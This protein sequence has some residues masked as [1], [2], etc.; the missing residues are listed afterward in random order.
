M[1]LLLFFVP[2]FNF[3]VCFLSLLFSLFAFFL[4]AFSFARF[5]FIGKASLEPADYPRVFLYKKSPAS[6]SGR[7]VYKH[8]ESSSISTGTVRMQSNVD[9]SVVAAA[10][11]QSPPNI[12]AKL[13]TLD[14]VG[15]AAITYSATIT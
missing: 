8:Y 15:I 2:Y 6:K 5:L 12:S 3:L 11:S 10:V 4:I 7:F 13:S 9:I 14:A 1:P